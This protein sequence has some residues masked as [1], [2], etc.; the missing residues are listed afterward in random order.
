MGYKDLLVHLDDGP[1][2]A[3]RV[4]VALGLAARHGAH[5]T[6]LYTI[7]EGPLAAYVRAHVPADLR[8]RLEAETE[9]R[10]EA[11]LADFRDAAERAGV[12]WETR[13]ERTLD[14]PLARVLSV[15][16]RSADL[17]VLGQVGPD[18]PAGAPRHLP[19]EVVMASGRPVL[20]VPESGAFETLGE[21]VVVAWDASRA[22]ARAVGD[23]MPILERAAS[24]LVVTVNPTEGH[25]EL[26]G[27]DIAVHLARHGIEV[28]VQTVETDQMS[29]GEVLLSFATDGGRD[30]LVMGAY[31]H[32]R[33]RQLVLGGVTRTVLERMTL[34]VLMAH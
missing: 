11:V 26:P 8:T 3:T 25:G 15:H 21:R 20:V 18:A 23:A 5:L 27:A 1:G 19:G 28:E 33:L 31:G 10:S 30:L 6:G 29:A 34:P 9:A 14:A 24:I 13:T 12:A 17:V 32:P 16:A 22:A 4:A 2:C 7:G